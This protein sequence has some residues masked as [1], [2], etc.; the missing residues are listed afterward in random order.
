MYLSACICLLAMYTLPYMYQGE[1]IISKSRSMS[2]KVQCHCYEAHRGITAHPDVS[3]NFQI[4]S[5]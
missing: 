2:V 5:F 3:L 1:D 4:Q